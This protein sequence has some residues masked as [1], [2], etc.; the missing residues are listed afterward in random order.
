MH[1]IKQS[2]HDFFTDTFADSRSH[3]WFFI[4]H[5]V[6]VRVKW[7]TFGKIIYIY[8]YIYIYILGFYEIIAD[9]SMTHIGSVSRSDHDSRRSISYQLDSIWR[10]EEMTSKKNAL[11]LSL[12]CGFI[13]FFFPPLSFFPFFSLLLASSI[14][15]N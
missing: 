3:M 2:K 1:G 15:V 13:I 5:R 7:A 8:I 11:S 9:K 14:H 12:S 4:N 6:C 10:L